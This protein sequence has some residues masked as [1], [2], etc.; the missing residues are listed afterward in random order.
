MLLR[1]C[2]QHLSLTVIVL[3]RDKMEL[4][5]RIPVAHISDKLDELGIKGIMDIEI[6]PIFDGARLAG[7]AITLLETVPRDA[8]TAIGP[9]EL[10]VVDRAKAGDVL[11]ISAPES[12]RNLALFGGVMAIGSQAKGLAGVVCD[13]AT[14]DSFE[15]RKRKFP[16]FTRGTSPIDTG[17]RVAAVGIDECVECGG[18]YV[19]PG[20][21]IVGDDDGVAVIPKANIDDIIEYGTAK[22][23]REVL[24]E[25]RIREGES[26]MKIYYPALYEEDRRKKRSS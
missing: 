15:I 7:P 19:E 25:K 20:D 13:G 21:F 17:R 3:A 24:I 8:K 23:E 2:R 4:L 26:V 9:W 18:V 5:K 14:R 16:C 10:R 6:K 22:L 12:A 11:V 1:R